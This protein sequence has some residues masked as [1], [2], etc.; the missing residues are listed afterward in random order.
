METENVELREVEV[1]LTNE[2]FRGKF[3]GW[4][5]CINNEIEDGEFSYMMGVVESSTNGQVVL[6]WPDKIIFLY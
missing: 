2:K 5:R 6:I 1:N 4:T 3:H